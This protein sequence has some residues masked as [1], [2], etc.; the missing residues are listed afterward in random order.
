MA[1]EGLRLFLSRTNMQG[2][3][4]FL[5]QLPDFV[6]VISFIQAEILLLLFGWLW[7]DNGET[8]QR[9]TGHLEII[10]VSPFNSQTDRESM[11]FH[12]QTS[13]HAPFRSISWVRSSLLLTQWRFRHRPVHR[14]PFPIE[15]FEFIV[16][17]QPLR[18]QL[19]ENTCLCPFLKT[20]VC[21][22][23]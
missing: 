20:S 10:A 21:T 1:F 17:K 7:S 2:V 12:E 3:A 15:T 18:P 13:F 23:S 4:K 16:I 5:A 14:L 19:P 9:S 8:F 6:V 11:T 22:T